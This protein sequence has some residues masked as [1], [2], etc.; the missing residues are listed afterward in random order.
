[1]TERGVHV[2]EVT[3]TADLDGHRDAWQA[4][5]SRSARGDLFNSFEWLRAW[6]SAFWSGR[7]IS[8]RFVWRGR[9]L[10]GVV[11]LLPDRLG[12]LTCR[13]TLVTAVNHETSRLSILTDGDD[14]AV[15]EA[16]L[17]DEARR[18]GRPRLVFKGLEVDSH[19]CP[20]LETA[21]EAV[22]LRTIARE[23]GASPVIEFDGTWTDYLAQRTRKTRHEMGRKRRKFLGVEG[24]RWRI[25]SEPDDVEEALR[26]VLA[27]ER[28]SWKEGSGTSIATEEGLDDFYRDLARRLADSGMLRIYVLEALGLPIAHVYCAVRGNILYALKTSYRMDH[29]RLSPGAVIIGFMLEDACAAGYGVVDLLGA[30]DGWKTSFATGAR[31]THTVCVASPT[32]PRCYGC[33]LLQSRIKPFAR[34]RFPGALAWRN[35]RA[36]TGTKGS[37]HRG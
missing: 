18:P 12:E 35:A 32:A 36:A 11:P 30:Q 4:L 16:V 9:E 33:W 34:R 28:E 15:L 10:I 17:R 25:A 2:E 27:V 21:A 19:L 31:E 29:A 37:S 6:L 22:G 1:M 7:P 8:F 23:Q 26:A 13:N 20:A 24:A 3:R 14:E 5:H